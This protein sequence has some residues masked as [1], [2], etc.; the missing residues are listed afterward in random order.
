M[1]VQLENRPVTS[2]LLRRV[3]AEV[4]TWLSYVHG[5]DYHNVKITAEPLGTIGVVMDEECRK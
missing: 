4:K 2:S 5:C 3:D 1:L